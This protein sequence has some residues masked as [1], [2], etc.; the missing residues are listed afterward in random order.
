MLSRDSINEEFLCDALGRVSCGFAC[1]AKSLLEWFGSEESSFV[2][3]RRAVPSKE[4]ND[5]YQGRANLRLTRVGS[6]GV[7]G[8]LAEEFSIKS[9]SRWYVVHIK[10]A[11]R[12]G[13]VFLETQAGRVACRGSD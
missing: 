12:S 5:I 8:V 9:D 10:S 11:D 2:V 13:A 3:S 1:E 6:A 7:A 4:L